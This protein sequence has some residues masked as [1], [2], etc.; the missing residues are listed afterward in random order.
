MSQDT[1]HENL[2]DENEVEKTRIE[3]DFRTA[4][5][6]LTDKRLQI[7]QKLGEKKYE[8]FTEL[9]KDLGRD[10]KNVSEDLKALVETG[11]VDIEQEGRTKK[12]KFEFEKIEITPIEASKITH[13]RAKE[14]ES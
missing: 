8:S 12:P 3:I 5:K 6:V 11:I 9:V 4:K 7:I 14:I 13:S 10:K 1:E 2:F